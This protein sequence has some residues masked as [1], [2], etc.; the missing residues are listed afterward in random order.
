VYLKP[1]HDAEIDTL[2]GR[3]S[4]SSRDRT[5]GRSL[6]L[7]REFEYT[8]MTKML[9]FLK[10]MGIVKRTKTLLDVGGYIGMISIGFVLSGLFDSSIVFEP[11]PKNYYY[12]QRNINLN[13]L[14]RKIQSYNL[15]LSD[16]NSKMIMELSPKNYGDHRIRLSDQD[17]I[18][19]EKDRKVISIQSSAL[20][21]LNIEKADLVWM[22]IQGHEER[23]FR[24]ARQYLKTNQIPVVTEFWP[25][26]LFRSG[27]TKESYLEAVSEIFQHFIAIEDRQPAVIQEIAE[28]ADLFGKYEHGD[29]G[30]HVIFF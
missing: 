26:G 19:G 25:Y 12:L 28:I 10:N 14:D 4:F 21:S 2:N 24:G 22:D 3:L 13:Q 6:Y 23:F 9:S 11:D 1:E 18:F 17:G 8:D 30:A 27:S 29:G 7:D 20:D 5:L 15:A 16:T